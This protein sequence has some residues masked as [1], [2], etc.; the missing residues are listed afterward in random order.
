MEQLRALRQVESR[1]SLVGDRVSVLSGKLE[2][3]LFR[4][5]RI[6]HELRRE[7][8][9]KNTDAMF[10]YDLQSFRRDVRAFGNDAGGFSSTLG[11]LERSARYDEESLAHAQAAM[12]LADRLHK[13][14]SALLDKAVLAHQ[15]MREADHKVEAWYMIQEIGSL[16][17]QTQALPGLA[18]KVLVAIGSR[19]A[20]APS[21]DGERPPSGG[22]ADGKDVR[23]VGT[24]GTSDTAGGPLPADGA[25]PEAPPPVL[26]RRAA[27][28]LRPV[29]RL[30]T[31]VPAASPQG[32]PR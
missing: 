32:E 23:P 24:G 12:R 3:L 18:N 6:A 4:A 10:G 7:P 17:Q 19:P 25:S 20:A 30:V 2:D 11:S 15:Y 22:G 28:P 16:A 1:L 31:G 29:G 9:A 27:V 26:Q 13:N 21:G 8:K 14:L 5:Q